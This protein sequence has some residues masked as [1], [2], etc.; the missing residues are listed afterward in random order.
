MTFQSLCIRSSKG[1]PVTI[2]TVLS[3]LALPLYAQESSGKA[4]AAPTDVMKQLEALTK[5]VEQLEQQLREHELGLQPIT[6]VPSAKATARAQRYT[7]PVEAA[8]IP[9]QS[10]SLIVQPAKP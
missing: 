3:F 9:A 4:Q 2:L 5:R 8:V 7:A 1:F 10:Q 6:M